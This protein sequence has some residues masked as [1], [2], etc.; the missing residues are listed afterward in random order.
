MEDILQIGVITS[1]HGVRGEVKVFPMTDD[2]KR[3]SLLKTCLMGNDK[4]TD[5][6]GIDS[7]KYFKQFVII[8]FAGIESRD[9]AE[10][11]RNK[12]LYVRRDQAVNLK[13][14]EYFI[15]DLI[16]CAVYTDEGEQL[17]H[18]SDVYQTGAN[19]VYVV[20]DGCEEILIPAIH[21]CILS[22]DVD[23]RKIIVHLLEG[24]RS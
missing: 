8:K 11:L 23:E 13:K 7:V 4:K 22:V 6:I 18:I 21:D 14:D 15:A 24:L 20:T 3:F 12:N 19:D 16:D 10:K 1:V 9:E 2:P 5:E 17:G